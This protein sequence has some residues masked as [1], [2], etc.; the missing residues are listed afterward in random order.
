[1]KITQENAGR[2]AALFYTI[3][4]AV[5]ALAFAVAALA[6]GFE[7]VAVIGGAGWVF[8]LTLIILMPTVTPWVRSRAGDRP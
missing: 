1:M 5:A 8:L 4:S 3:G 7:A 6:G 2:I